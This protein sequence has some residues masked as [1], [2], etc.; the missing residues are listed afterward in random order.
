[1]KY[2]Q[3]QYIHTCQAYIGAWQTWQY[4]LKTER[5]TIIKM[6]NC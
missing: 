6:G 1:M 4:D 5:Y 3:I 2:K